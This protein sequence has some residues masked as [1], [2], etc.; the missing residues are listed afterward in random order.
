M[1]VCLGHSGE[2]EHG[3]CRARLGLALVE[4]G[5][6]G[7]RTGGDFDRRPVADFYPHHAVVVDHADPRAGQVPLVEDRLHLGLAALLGDDE[8][9]FLRLGQE[10]LVRRHAR[11][12]LGDEVQ[13]DLDPAAAAAGCF[14]S[15]T[16]QP[17]RAHILD[18]GDG[19]GLE[20]FEAGFEQEL[21]L[22]GV[23]DLHGRAVFLGLFG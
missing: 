6:V 2:V 1:Q 13:V 12:A 10:N 9:A 5:L 18:A 19:V 4:R 16:R 3:F 14:A 22:E 23:A 7:Q 8:H 11:F 15:R 21:F 17:R 20:E